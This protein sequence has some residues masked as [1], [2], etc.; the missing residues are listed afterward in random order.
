MKIIY[1]NQAR[2][3][4]NSN[5]CIAKEYPLKDNDI[6]ISVVKVVGRYPEKGRVTNLKCK[7]LLYIAKG[8]GSVFIEGEKIDFKEGDLILIEPKEKYYWDCQATMVV[9]CAP[10]WYPEQHQEID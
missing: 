10:A 7:E 3:F 9:P 5:L 8:S 2:E 1:A 6:N 4:K